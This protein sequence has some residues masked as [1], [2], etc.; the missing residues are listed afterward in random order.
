[1][2]D[3]VVCL[4]F[5]F[6]CGVGVIQFRVGFSVLVSRC[7]GFGFG[8]VVFV[9]VCLVICIFLA[10]VDCCWFLLG[11]GVFVCFSGSVWV[12]AG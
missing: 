7:G 12:V 10:Y 8:L 3:R 6:F 4:G 11:F 5:L 1:M 2:A 9:L